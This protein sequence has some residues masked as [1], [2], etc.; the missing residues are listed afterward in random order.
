MTKEFLN[1]ELEVAQA[2]AGVKESTALGRAG[3]VAATSFFSVSILM[4]I[5]AVIFTV[6]F[7][8]SEVVG[9]SMMLNLNPGIDLTLAANHP[10]QPRDT[11]L[12]NRYV[13]PKRFDIIVVKHEYPNG[14][15]DANGNT[16]FE[17][18]Y[19]K[20]LIAFAGERVSFK[21]YGDVPND[22]YTTLV[23]GEEIDESG[24]LDPEYW[25]KMNI[26]G[27][28][29]YDYLQSSDPK[30]H[31]LGPSTDTYGI[32]DYSEFIVNHEI[33]IPDGYIFFMGDNRGGDNKG[34]YDGYHSW[35]CTAFG[36]QPASFILGVAVERIEVGTTIPQYVWEKIKLF[37]SFKW[38]FG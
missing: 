32:E 38:L 34:L 8:I 24:Y 14:R 13:T 33:V 31:L 36:P 17:E 1:Q 12:A 2:G 26:Y 28:K 23:N 18:W 27:R 15:T 30:A 10:D 3:K 20:R 16:I 7:F 25:G 21:K 35:D 5:G 29:V 6:I 9:S 11:V 19:I 4:T 22:Y 37:F